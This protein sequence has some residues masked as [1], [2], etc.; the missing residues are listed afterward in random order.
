MKSTQ[1]KSGIEWLRRAV[2]AIPLLV[3]VGIPLAHLLW[4]VW[5]AHR[6]SETLAR[7]HAAGEPV[8]PG[9]LNLDSV[10]DSRNAS[11]DYRAAGD[12]IDT[13]TKTW[14]RF[15]YSA[16]GE[17]K[18][19]LTDPEIKTI[20][21][22]VSA[23]SSALN[24]VASAR[25]KLAGGWNDPFNHP[26]P[27]ALLSLDGVRSLCNLL[28]IA[29]LDAHLHGDDS[30]SVQ[31]LSDAVSVAD[32][33]QHRP[34]LISHLVATGATSLACLTVSEL[35]PEL[36]V[37]AN[38]L[39]RAQ[40]S[41]LLKQL[42]DERAMNDG[43]MLSWRSE[44]MVGVNGLTDIATGTPAALAGNTGTSSSANS[45]V[46]GYIAKPV[47]LSDARLYA[48]YLQGM[49]SASSATDW[50]SAQSRLPTALPAMVHAHPMYHLFLS[51]LVPS[52]D[53]AA[54]V[55]FDTR[56]AR[57]LAVVAIAVRLYAA[58]HDN[59]LPAS[60]E[61]LV[62]RYLPTIPIDPMSG[63]RLKYKSNPPRIYSIGDDG[64]DD[65]GVPVDPDGNRFHREHGDIV[66]YL[67]TQPRK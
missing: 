5:A 57:R 6:L 27:N 39:S 4:G 53:K 23:N 15:L 41:G 9:Q 60:L 63:S 1:A 65:G 13:S 20:R 28:K 22:I 44:R 32:A 45:R 40:V 56:A 11:L 30:A 67:V 17:F 43:A 36:H 24:Q 55:G 50:P 59:Q 61:E 10:P 26:S 18:L 2:I 52:L 54:K 14:K 46:F 19:P 35:A 51:L 64:V 8:L 62:P 66:V 42:Q 47:L 7:L 33:S 29:A 12:S 34:T 38:G 3:I 49:I 31:R 37:S 16:S 25:G 48:E 21:S 58:D